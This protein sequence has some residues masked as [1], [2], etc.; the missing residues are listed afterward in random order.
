M[1]RNLK[2]SVSGSTELIFPDDVDGTYRLRE[3]SVYDAGEVRDELDGDVPQYGD[4]I[5]VE[6]DGDEAW[7]VAP[8]DLRAQL[9]D[10][11]IRTGERFTIDEMVKTGREQSDPY[12]VTVTLPDREDVPDSQKSLSET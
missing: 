9:I 6:D 8:S 1:P 3:R 11:E 2:D 10:R 4:W 7:L 5:P 12:S